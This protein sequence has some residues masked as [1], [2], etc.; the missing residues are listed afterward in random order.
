MPSPS[1]IQAPSASST[2]PVV[3]YV[4]DTPAAFAG[5]TTLADLDTHDAIV[6]ALSTLHS[7]SAAS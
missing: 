4:A 7:T 1:S 6:G 3:G 2:S 5:L